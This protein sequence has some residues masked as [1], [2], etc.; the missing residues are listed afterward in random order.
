[1]SWKPVVAEQKSLPQAYTIGNWHNSCY[2]YQSPPFRLD[3]AS[4][5]IFGLQAKAQLLHQ[6]LFSRYLN[7]EDLPVDTPAV[8]V[9][10]TP[11]EPIFL[12]ETFPATCKVSSS[13]PGVE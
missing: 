3:D 5:P 7:V 8:A 12:L 6:T 4:E 2:R 13:A 10:S 1:M 9:L 11:W